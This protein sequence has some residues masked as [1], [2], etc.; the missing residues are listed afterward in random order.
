MPLGYT[1]ELINDIIILIIDHTLHA[2]VPMIALGWKDKML[3]GLLATCG[4]TASGRPATHEE[5]ILCV[6]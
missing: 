1:I 6:R 3:K 5:I 4:T 2:G